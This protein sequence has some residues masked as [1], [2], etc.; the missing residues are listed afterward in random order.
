MKTKHLSVLLAT[1]VSSAAAI[2]ANSLFGTP[3]YTIEANGA[4]GGYSGGSDSTGYT[5]IPNEGGADITVLWTPNDVNEV[6]DSET[7]DPTG[8]PYHIVST[9][10]TVIGSQQSKTI[11]PTESIRIYDQVTGATKSGPA[12]PNNTTVYGTYTATISNTSVS[13]E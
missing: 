5:D 2:V 9:P 8:A 3:T 12:Y 11:A 4:F 7:L 10:A 6:F 13:S 1:L